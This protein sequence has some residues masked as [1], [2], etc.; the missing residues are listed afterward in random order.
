MFIVWMGGFYVYDVSW[1]FCLMLVVGFL[2][3]VMAGFLV[4]GNGWVFVLIVAVVFFLFFF[5]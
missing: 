5:V 3:I 2:F 4:Y 1:V